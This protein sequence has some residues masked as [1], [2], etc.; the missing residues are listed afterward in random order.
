MLTKSCIYIFYLF[1]G[2]FCLAGT[3]VAGDQCQDCPK[4]T[5]SD[6][7]NGTS[8]TDCPTGSTTENNGT[9]NQWECGR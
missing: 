3:V 8:C 2:L 6:A 1:V 4:G 9:V 7:N 5:Y